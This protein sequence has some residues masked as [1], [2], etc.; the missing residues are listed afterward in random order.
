MGR[1]GHHKQIPLVCVGST[2][3][4][5]WATLGLPPLTACVLSPSTLLR[6]QVSL[7][8]VGPDLCALSRPKPLKIRFSGTPQKCRL[9]WACVLCLP[10][11]SSSGNQELDECT[12]PRCSVPFPLLSPGLTFQACCSCCSVCLVSLLGSCFLTA[13]LPVD[14]NHPESQEVFG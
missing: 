6:H 10:W 4:N 1:E 8:G 9:G 5:V 2:G 11:P 7:Q 3:S 12:L 14:V 13:T